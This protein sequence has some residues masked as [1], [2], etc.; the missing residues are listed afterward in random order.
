M[1]NSPVDENSSLNRV[2][3]LPAKDNMFHLQKIYIRYAF[4][5]IGCRLGLFIAGQLEGGKVRI[6]RM[7]LVSTDH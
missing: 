6:K 4:R 2:L 7:N 3:L 1:T 5:C